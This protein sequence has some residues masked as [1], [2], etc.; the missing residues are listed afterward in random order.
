MAGA[1]LGLYTAPAVKPV[2][3]CQLRPSGDLY[4]APPALTRIVPGLLGAE[5]ISIAL[6]CALSTTV[7]KVRFRVPFVTVTGN[8]R[9][10]AVFGAAS[11][12]AR[13][14]KFESTC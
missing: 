9:S 11:G 3:A 14:S 1:G 2:S 4:A 10:S 12:C 5:T 8:D 6:T 13:I 7:A